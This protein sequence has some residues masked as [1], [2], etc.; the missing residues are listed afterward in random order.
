M[1]YKE[2]SLYIRQFIEKNIKFVV[3][4]L[5]NRKVFNVNDTHLLNI[6]YPGL[7]FDYN[8]IMNAL[9]LIWKVKLNEVDDH[10]I[11]KAKTIIKTIPD[12][13]E[14]IFQRKNQDLR[15]I[16]NNSKSTIPCSQNF[17]KRKFDVNISNHFNIAMNSTSE[18]RL[19]LLHF[20]ILHNIYPTSIML[21]KMKIKDS[22]LCETCQTTD[23][24]EH[25]F[26]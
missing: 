15:S 14:H 13:I 7:I 19:R 6:K 8:A 3:D 20:K 11:L 26:C 22:N 25:F 12:C 4:L 10:D 5:N 17:W 21:Q 24:L 18:T 1:K 9:P 16:F 2:K 23:Y